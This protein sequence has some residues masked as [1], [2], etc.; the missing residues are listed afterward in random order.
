MDQDPIRLGY[1]PRQFSAA[2]IETAAHHRGETI[3]AADASGCVRST[4]QNME[5]RFDNWKICG[6][7][8]SERVGVKADARSIGPAEV[9]GDPEVLVEIA[10]KRSVPAIQTGPSV[11]M[12]ELIATKQLSLRLCSGC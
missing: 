11:W 2:S 9:G 10:G 5:E 1:A 4:N 3:S 8:R 12:R 6:E 7:F